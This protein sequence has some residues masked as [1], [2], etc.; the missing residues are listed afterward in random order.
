MLDFGDY[1][2]VMCTYIRSSF[3]VFALLYIYVCVKA[4]KETR[5]CGSVQAYNA[6]RVFFFFLK[7]KKKKK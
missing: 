5:R 4:E 3:R 7:K 6:T 2:Y 1:V